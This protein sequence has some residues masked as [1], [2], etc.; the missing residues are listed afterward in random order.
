MDV[1]KSSWREHKGTRF[2][3]ADYSNFGRNIEGLRQEVNGADSEIEQSLGES[4]LVLVDIRN[5][6]TSTDVVSLFKES[7][8][9]TKGHVH[10]TAI[11]GVTGV[12]KILAAAVARFSRETLH[13][14]SETAEA[15]DWLVG[16]EEQGGVTIPP[17]RT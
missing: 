8:A 4:A 15:M 13:L 17:S 11:V 5:T 16:S 10:K 12:Q 1:M 3:Y 2:F 9:R 14:F 7:T 6:V